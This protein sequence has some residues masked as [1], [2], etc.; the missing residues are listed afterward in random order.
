MEEIR[1]NSYIA[2]CGVASRRK[3]DELIKNGLVFV[4]GKKV[5]DMGHKVT[6]KDNVLVNGMCIKRNDEKV[7]ILLNKPV[8]VI[9]SS[10]DQ[11]ERQ[12]VMDIIGDVGTRLHT[13]GRLDYD[14][15]GIIILTN[16]GDLTYK[17]THPKY[18]IQ[19]TY[20]VKVAGILTKEDLAMLRNG[21][22][23]DNNYKTAPCKVKILK[24]NKCTTNVEITI[25]EGKNRQIRKMFAKLGH[26]VQKLK[27]IRI[28]HI[29]IG[30]LKEGR[31]RDLGKNDIEKLLN[32]N[33]NTKEMKK[34]S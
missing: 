4:N 29:E 15:S 13:V 24:V 10:K 1:L 32:K 28:G 25:Y 7:Y 22:V 8:G 27:R 2:K 18:H 14:T 6:S 3:A 12:T 17:L 33:Y 34:Q 16:D 21:I 26:E 11:F 23:I 5:C 31:W 9:S 19:K 30:N 20:L